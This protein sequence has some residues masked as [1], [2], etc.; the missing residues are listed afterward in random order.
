MPSGVL[1]KK[2]TPKGQRE[3][4]EAH[5]GIREDAFEPQG[6][7]LLEILHL[8]RVLRTREEVI[9]YQLTAELAGLL[10]ST[11]PGVML[12]SSAGPGAMLFSS[13]EPG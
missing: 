10:A 12:C 13:T 1:R 2:K 4:M 3:D 7:L 8:L 9:I 6:R 5:S 11:G